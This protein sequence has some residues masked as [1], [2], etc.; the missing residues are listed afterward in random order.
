MIFITLG[1]QKFQFNRLLKEIDSLVAN[2]IIKDEIFAQI[3]SSDYIPKNYN[4]SFFLNQND[5]KEKMESCEIVITHAG[6]GAIIS[7]LKAE[8]KVIAV[9]RLAKY[10]EHVDDHQIQI[11]EQFVNANYIEGCFNCA[12]LSKSIVNVKKHNYNNF[13]SNTNCFIKDIEQFISE[14]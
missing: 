14:L 7:A 8:K 9:P 3:G 2:K 6:T 13:T 11:V 5:F 12:D 4:Y 10:N 1:S